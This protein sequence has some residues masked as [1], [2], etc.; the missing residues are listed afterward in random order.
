M[1]VSPSAG[2]VLLPDSLKEAVLGTCDSVGVWAE[3][4]GVGVW[5]WV[6]KVGSFYG[7]SEM[8]RKESGAVTIGRGNCV[9]AHL[10]HDSPVHLCGMCCVSI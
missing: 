7:G 2:A 10:L 8:L 3:E 4:C 5:D 1:T 9:S 6:S